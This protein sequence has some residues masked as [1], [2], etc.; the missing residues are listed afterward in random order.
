M[1]FVILSLCERARY[2]IHVPFIFVFSFVNIRKNS[3][4][5][6]HSPKKKKEKEEFFFFFISSYNW[7]A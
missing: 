5:H 2:D 7:Y 3:I 4:Y 1:K 6:P